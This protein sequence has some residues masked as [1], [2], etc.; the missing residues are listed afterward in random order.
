MTNKTQWL[1]HGKI[2]LA[3]HTVREPIEEGSHPLLLLHGLGERTP[4]TLLDEFTSWPGLISGLDFTGHGLSDIPKGGG[5][6]AELL[7][8]DADAALDL[9]GPATVCGRGLGAYVALMLAGGR[10]RQVRG[11]IL[12]DGPGLAGGGPQPS[13]PQI[14]HPDPHCAPPPDPMAMAELS[15]DIRPADYAMSYVLQAT[16]LSPVIHPITVCAIQKTKWITA[17]CEAIETEE[18]TLEDALETYSRFVPNEESEA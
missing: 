18:S 11:A 10:P 1:R 2:K 12:C 5:Y 15:N 14:I 9:I 16:H 7:M 13:N 4:E 6:T 17:V 3:L 8:G